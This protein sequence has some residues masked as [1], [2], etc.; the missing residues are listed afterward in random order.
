MPR[1]GARPGTGGRRPGAGRPLGSQ[2]ERTKSIHTRLAEVGRK[3]AEIIGDERLIK[4]IWVWALKG[5]SACLRLCA[6]YMWGKIREAPDLDV[7]E[8]VR[9]DVIY[10]CEIAEPQPSTGWK[11]PADAPDEEEP[12]TPSRK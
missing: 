6:E 1:G 10:R 12:D 9:G 11:A 2:N 8:P 7:E 5:D 3:F 4:A